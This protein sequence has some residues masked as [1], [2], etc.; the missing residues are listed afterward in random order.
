VSSAAADRTDGAPIAIA[1]ESWLDYMNH[2]D[3]GLLGSV[4]DEDSM[5]ADRR[6]EP[7]LTRTL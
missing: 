1:H 4:S 7:A 5:V 2:P 3:P 6:L